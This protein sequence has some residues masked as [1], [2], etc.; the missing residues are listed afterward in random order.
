VGDGE[1]L[2]KDLKVEW[3]LQREDYEHFKTNEAEITIQWTILLL[4][5][6]YLGTGENDKVCFTGH[7]R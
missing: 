1:A 4:F 5:V 3:R 2:V 7:G 6:V